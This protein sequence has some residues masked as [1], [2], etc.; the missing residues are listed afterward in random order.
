MCRGLGKLSNVIW[1]CQ[2]SSLA[3][4]TELR[5]A[6]SCRPWTELGRRMAATGRRWAPVVACWRA[7]KETTR[8][9]VQ[10]RSRLQFLFVPPPLLVHPLTTA[11]AALVIDTIACRSAPHRPRT[12]LSPQ[13]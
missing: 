13:S 1:R 3:L 4:M 9:S 11:A 6:N 7:L 10:S 12:P 8:G 2:A 5:R